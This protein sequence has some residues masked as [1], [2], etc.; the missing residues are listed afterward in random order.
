MTALAASLPVRR[1]ELVI[2]PLG[3]RGRYVVKDPRG[4]AY[5]QV[6]QHEHLLRMQLDGVHAADAVCR[7]FEEQFAEPLSPADLEGFLAIARKKGLL[8][9]RVGEREGGGGGDEQLQQPSPPSSPTPTL[10][11]SSPL[12]PA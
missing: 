5:F 12:S 2:R 1:A 9:E 4:G 7:A 10:S 8:A 3:E 11:P 6:G